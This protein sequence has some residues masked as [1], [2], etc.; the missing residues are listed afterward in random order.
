MKDCFPKSR[1]EE[2]EEEEVEKITKLEMQQLT[3]NKIH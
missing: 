1:K 2:E 3:K